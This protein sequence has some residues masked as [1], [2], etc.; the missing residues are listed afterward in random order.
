MT[1]LNSIEYE[2]SCSEC[3][4]RLIK[5]HVNVIEGDVSS[6]IVEDIGVIC[7]NCEA[8]LVSAEDDL[9]RALQAL[10]DV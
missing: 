6:F 2:L 9:Y 7:P 3:Q 8:L 10:L 4:Y 5:G 1:T